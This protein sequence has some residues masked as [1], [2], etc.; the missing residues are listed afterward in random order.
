MSLTIIQLRH[1]LAMTQEAFG[2]EVGLSKGKVSIVEREQ[3]CSI[4]VALAIEALS[5]GRIDA[6]TLNDDVARVRATQ[7]RTVA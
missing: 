2:A 5:G 4:P 3:R 1:E 7:R 6:A